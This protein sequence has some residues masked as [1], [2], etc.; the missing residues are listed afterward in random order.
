MA[1][2]Y[3]ESSS[4]DR[5]RQALGIAGA[6]GQQKEDSFLK[7]EPEEVAERIL[8]VLKNEKVIDERSL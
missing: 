2:A 3:A 5:M 8:T 4:V 6:G 1:N 7:G